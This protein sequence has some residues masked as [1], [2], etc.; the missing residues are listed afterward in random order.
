MCIVNNT[1]MYTS[2]T[3]KFMLCVFH[4]NLKI[5]KSDSFAGEADPQPQ[6]DHLNPTPH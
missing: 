3:D 6:A 2:K 5:K 1:L 4:H